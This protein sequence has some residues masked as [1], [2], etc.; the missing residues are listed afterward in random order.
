MKK[1][2][3]QEI[4]K[5]SGVS[6]ST[7]SR[8]I[9]NS[10]SVS[11]AKRQKIQAIIDEYN[12]TPS[13]FARGMVNKQT[14]NI[15]VILP[16]ISNPYFISLVTQIQKFA[17]DYMFSTIL[18]NTMLAEPANKKNKHPL[19]EE[20]YLKIILEKQVDGL[21]ILGGEIDKEVISTEYI[22]A[23]NQLNKAIPVVVIGSKIPELSCLFIERNL[24]KGVTT[25]VSHLTALGH[26][27]IGFIGGEAGVKI[28][29]YRLE[30][31]KE[32]M[33]SYHHPVNDDWV[34]LS[35]YYTADGYSAMTELLTNSAENLPTALVA[36]NDSVAIGAIR[37]INDANL[38]CPEDIA[39]VSCDQFMN[40]DFQTPRLTSMDQHNEYLGKMAL[41]QLISAING[42]NEPMIINHNPEL[43]IRES[44]GSKL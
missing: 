31:F 25:L 16:D 41:L 3:I 6:V 4:A 30:S 28:T 26:E 32:A 5:L 20:D 13:V 42:Q 44:C 27:N 24:K 19:T 12:Y 7:V 11:A 23:L 10:P 36:I 29:T 15:G 9:N 1:I 40:G 18:F 39:I 43:I 17:L 14:K 37:A 34:V 38:S 21:L 22:D 2:T 33:A 8:V 35:D